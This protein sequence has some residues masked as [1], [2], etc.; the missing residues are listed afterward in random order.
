M[1]QTSPIDVR[2]GLYSNIVLSGGSTMF[3]HFG[4]RL[5]RDLK[6]I[7]DQRIASSEL[8]SGSHMRS[9][10]VDVNVISHK[11]QRY[12][13]W[14]GGSLLASTPEFYSYCHDRQAYQEY[15]AC[16]SLFFCL[17]ASNALTLALALRAGP[18]LVRR[19]AIFGSATD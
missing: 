4:R 1:I 12:A 9:S 15:G 17:P 8:A 3:D 13:V 11:K 19:F 2:R 5:Q 7:V 10:G 6:G 16:S 14:F 18:S